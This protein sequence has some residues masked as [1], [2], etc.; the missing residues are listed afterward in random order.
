MKNIFIGVENNWIKI[1]GVIEEEHL[2]NFFLPFFEIKT[3]VPTY[4]AQISIY[5]SSESSIREE[6]NLLTKRSICVNKIVLHKSKK[7]AHHVEGIQVREKHGYQYLFFENAIVKA[8][9][10]FKN[11]EIY[12]KNN[13]T[14]YSQILKVLIRGLLKNILISKGYILM[15]GTA[16]VT[17]DSTL[18]LLGNKGA[19]KTTLALEYVKNGAKILA[20]DRVLIGINPHLRLI[21]WPTYL[22]I[23]RFTLNR[24]MEIF[25]DTNLEKLDLNETDGK[26]PFIAKDIASILSTNFKQNIEILIPEFKRDCLQNEI[27]DIN[28]NELSQ[29]LLEQYKAVINDYSLP[30]IHKPIN[31]NSDTIINSLSEFRARKYIYS[32]TELKGE[33]DN[34]LLYK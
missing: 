26:I 32:D 18:L 31:N 6:I 29:I 16:L 1:T 22:N 3:N 17:N 24:N 7:K 28:S 27:L 15:H 33:S 34:E 11:I 19:G 12:V 23:T 8:N 9:N 20:F 21:G 25:K 4:L 30:G 10:K 2:E 5:S 13:T 14:K